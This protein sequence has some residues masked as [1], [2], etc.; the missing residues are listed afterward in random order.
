[1]ADYT[2]LS[3]ENIKNLLALYDLGDLESMV[4]MKGGQ[5][6]SSVKIK[7][8]KGDYTLSVCDEKTP[9]EL[10][11]LTR[12]LSHLEIHE[13]PTPRLIPARN[14]DPFISLGDKPVY[15][16]KFLKGQVCQTLSSAM[17]FQVGHAMARL[18]LLSPPPGLPR[19]FPYG[20]NTFETL[21][22]TRHPYIDWLRQKKREIEMKIDP[23]LAKGFI[24]GDL[25]WDNLVFSSDTLVAILD[26]EEACY[27]YKL[28][29]LGMCVVGCCVQRK[30]LSMDLIKHLLAGYQEVCPLEDAEKIQLPLFMEYAAVAASFWRF[31]QYN[32]RY[33]SIEKKDAYLELSSLA[34]LIHSMN[35]GRFV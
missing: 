14:R 28:F 29:D 5:A 11:C 8:K 33:P 6:N 2:K 31:R 22:D 4:P 23:T 18:H 17:L 34:D 10:L 19:H 32:I 15:V 25:F 26:F 21:F 27:Y 16:K 24:H 20:L 9:E 30:A 35:P 3:R 1:M 12:V 7:T 13:F